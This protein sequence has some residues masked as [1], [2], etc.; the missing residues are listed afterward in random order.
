MVAHVSH[1][2]PQEEVWGSHGKPPTEKRRSRWPWGRE[3]LGKQDRLPWHDQQAWGKT[4]VPC[5]LSREMEAC[6]LRR[7]EGTTRVGAS[8]PLCGRSL[9]RRQAEGDSMS[10]A[11]CPKDSLVLATR[12][13]TRNSQKQPHGEMGSQMP[14]STKMW[15]CCRW[16]GVCQGRSGDSLPQYPIPVHG[17]CAGIL[18]PPLSCGEGTGLGPESA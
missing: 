13:R 15:Q 18:S 11:T 17:P 9:G 5:S 2:A 14:S 12:C 10:L 3:A 7:I 6:L 1:R 16:Q 8:A 4:S